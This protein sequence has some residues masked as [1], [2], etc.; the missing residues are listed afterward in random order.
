MLLIRFLWINVG[1]PGKCCDGA[2]WGSSTIGQN[3][4]WIKDPYHLVAD[5]AFPLS[6]QLLK[7]FPH[8][9]LNA[10]ETNFN[11]RLSRARMAIECA[12]GRLKGKCKLV[13][14]SNIC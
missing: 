14:V 1:Q 6:P 7:P 11:Y 12:F 9:N 4:S 8:E 2:V 3:T 10:I 13:L 5:S